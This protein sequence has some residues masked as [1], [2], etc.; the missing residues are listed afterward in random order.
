MLKDGWCELKTPGNFF[1]N[2]TS[3]H[4]LIGTNWPHVHLIGTS[5]PHVRHTSPDLDYSSRSCTLLEA[6]TIID[7]YD[8]QSQNFTR[9]KEI[10]FIVVM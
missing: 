2:M 5:W 4:R 8:F 3:F 1:S 9:F 6:P 7:D 10:Q